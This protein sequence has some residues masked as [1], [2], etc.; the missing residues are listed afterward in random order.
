MSRILALDWDEHEIRYLL[1]TAR[2]GRVSVQAFG[3]QPLVDISE[4][5]EKPRPDWEGSLRALLSD[6]QFSGARVVVGIESARV[7]LLTLDLPPAEDHEL[8][9]LVLLQVVRQLQQPPENLA[10]DFIPLEG[11]PRSR[12]K[13]LAAVLNREELDRIS[14]LFKRMKLKPARVV[15]RPLA[16][17]SLLKRLV[18]RLPSPCLVINRI[19]LQADLTLLV[20]GRAILFRSIRLPEAPLASQLSRLV[21]EAERTVMVAATSSL[22]G[23]KLAYCYVF[24][25]GE[26]HGDLAE[27]L[28][29]HLSTPAEVIDPLGAVDVRQVEI[30]QNLGRF[31]AHIGMVV[32]EATGARPEVDFLHVRR[33]PAKIKRA[34]VVAAVLGAVAVIAGI[35]LWSFWSQYSEIAS[36]NAALEAELRELNE[37]V[38]KAARTGQLVRAVADWVGTEIV[39]LDELAD[40]SLKLPGARHLVILRLTA[41]TTGKGS[42]S[43]FLQGVVRDPRILQQ[44][45]SGIRDSLRRVETPRIYE[46]ELGGEAT[47]SFESS[48]VVNRREPSQYLLASLGGEQPAEMPQREARAAEKPEVASSKLPNPQRVGANPAMAAQQTPQPKAP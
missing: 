15:F 29:E 10:V 23:E 46:R 22:A 36:E 1:A 41:T 45:E 11:D 42:G 9:E 6:R 35:G 14:S 7:E 47:W 4:G 24:G 39:W 25:S 33:P 5:G 38:K 28:A 3:S 48:V 8:P 21:L 37:A 27:R 13:V 16:V 18:P 43:I 2:R 34:H 19:G 17:A 12:R 40:L 20:D 32:D 30:P 44:M 26:E 31:S